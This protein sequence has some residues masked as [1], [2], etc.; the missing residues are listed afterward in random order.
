[1]NLNVTLILFGQLSRVI[2]GLV[3][4]L[5]ISEA[6]TKGRTK[7]DDIVAFLYSGRMQLWAFYTQTEQ[8]IELVGHMITEIREYPR[9]KMLVL[10]YCAGEPHYMQ[11]IE[12][13]MYDTLERYA[14]DAGCKGIEFIGRPGWKRSA[15]A[16]GY[17]SQSVIFE[18]YFE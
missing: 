8:V 12:D 10:Q 7:V 4:Y 14:K 5:E 2:P 11:H 9:C 18:K 3:K 13:Q 6:W 15:V 1:M 16:H 17:T